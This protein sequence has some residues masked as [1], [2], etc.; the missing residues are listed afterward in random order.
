VGG[1]TVQIGRLFRA[2]QAYYVML[3]DGLAAIGEV[4][5]LLLRAGG[6]SEV[7]DITPEVADV[8]R[9]RNFDPPGMPR[10]LWTM[11]QVPAGATICARYTSGNDPTSQTVTVDVHDQIPVVLS[12]NTAGEA[13]APRAGSDGFTSADR[14]VIRGALVRGLSHQGGTANTTVYLVTDD[15]RKYALPAA[16]GSGEGAGDKGAQA[17]LGYGS[18]TPTL[19]NEG[20]LELLPTGPVLD[21]AAASRWA[22]EAAASPTAAGN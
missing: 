16:E 2:N 13:G 8:Y 7:A 19:I 20:L 14:V 6:A 11:R 12:H 21:P 1:A 9:G 4:T 15:G 3:A 18:V 17:L 5:A 10:T 22:P